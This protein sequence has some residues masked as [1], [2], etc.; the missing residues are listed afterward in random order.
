M[1]K[2]NILS[3][4]VHLQEAW[5]TPYKTS[6][7]YQKRFVPARNRNWLQVA[8]TEVYMKLYIILQSITKI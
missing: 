8:M 2:K 6:S 1:Q 3:A 7:F 5:G 4:I